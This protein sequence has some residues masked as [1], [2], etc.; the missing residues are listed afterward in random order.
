MKIYNKLKI[1]ESVQVYQQYRFF[2]DT[3]DKIRILGIIFSL[4]LLS[5]L[6]ITFLFSDVN[7][8]EIKADFNGDGNDDVAIGIVT[9]DIGSMK[10]AG[11]VQVLYGSSSGLSATS[12]IADQFW[13]QD[14]T[15]VNDV[16][17]QGDAFGSFLSTGDFNGDGNDDLAVGVIGE[18]V[19]SM[20]DA[21]AVQVLYGS[22]SGLSATSPI[23][24]QFW[25][26]DSTN[27]T[28]AAEAG[29]F[30]GHYLSSGDFNGDG[31][32]DLT[33][34]VP[35]EDTGRK[36]SALV[37]DAGVV[38]VLYGSSSGLSATSPIADQFWTQNTQ[39]IDDV[40]ESGDFFGHS[41]SSGDFNGDGKD[42]LA[43][44]VPFEDVISGTTS[45]AGQV[46]V[47]Y[48]SSSGLSATSPIANQLWTQNTL[49]VNDIAEEGDLF[50]TYIS[51]GD[52]N[53][54]GNDDL[55]VGVD[56][57]NVGSI[58]NAGGVEVI[59]GSSS[60][61]SA[62]SP[63]ADQFWTQ[64]STNVNDLAEGDD[65]FGSSVSAG[66]F[67][68]DGNDD[69]AVGVDEENAGSIT[70]AGGVEVIY[71]SSSGLSATSPVADQFWTQDSTN[72]DDATEEGDLFG[73][74]ISASDYNGDGKDDLAI[75][76]P[77]EDIVSVEDAGAIQV[78]F[79]SSSGLSATSPIAD[80]FWTQDST[81]V[82]DVTEGFDRF[83]WP[84]G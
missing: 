81:N 53:G 1:I 47:L 6:S 23:A 55:A 61:L 31:K 77:N 66:D 3:L 13:T 84:L 50:G 43:I 63:T 49:N 78:L 76:L 26:Q 67:N 51:A 69:L 80:Q 27:V 29:D 56:E 57:E 33:I 30:F 12:P 21:G 59:Y 18:D 41:L 40:V 64:D 15:N 42:D 5:F 54:D 4:T 9:E 8:I 68:G 72:V 52:F 2:K 82:D 45:S 17:E 71:G 48:G 44:G 10:D 32:D 11:A 24:D 79:G 20:K 35:R 37:E 28:D 7:A 83:G 70:N 14:S 38:H 62:T 46:Q 73:R 19:G 75:G 22:S 65:F 34:G 58:T 36:P 74:F 60:G 25:T 39:N 16:A